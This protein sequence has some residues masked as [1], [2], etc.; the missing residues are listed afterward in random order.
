[1]LGEMPGTRGR[2][3]G[4]QRLKEDTRR[5][6]EKESRSGGPGGFG[7]TFGL[8]PVRSPVGERWRR[9]RSP[10]PRARPAGRGGGSE[11]GRRA[12]ERRAGGLVA[13]QGAG[14][15]RT[16]GG[17]PP[18]RA[19]SGSRRFGEGRP[20]H[21]PDRGW[22]APTA[23]SSSRGSPSGIQGERRPKTSRDAEYEAGGGALSK[24][25]ERWDRFLSADRTSPDP[26]PGR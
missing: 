16:Q 4:T 20:A 14:R 6:D 11:A 17:G 3:D 15:R 5:R 12:G 13:T 23:G 19:P 7:G 10:R 25:P 8:S 24:P 2:V 22:R 21:C 1:M 18:G 26:G 9:C